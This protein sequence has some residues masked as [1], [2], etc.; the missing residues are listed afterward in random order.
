[1]ADPTDT[2][3]QCDRRLFARG[4]C[5][6]HYRQWQIETKAVPCRVPACDGLTGILGTGKGYCTAHY[7]KLRTYGDPLH[8]ERK[9]N[10]CIIDGCDEV[11]CGHGLCSKHYT[12]QKR[13]GSTDDPRPWAH[14]DEGEQWCGACRQVKPDAEMVAHAH[15]AGIKRGTCRECIRSRESKRRADDPERERARHRRWYRDNRTKALATAARRRAAVRRASIIEFSHDQL[16]A[17]LTMF[18]GCWMCGTPDWSDIDHVKPIAAGGAHCLSNLRPAC[19]PCNRSK[20]ARW[21]YPM[22]A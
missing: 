18:P 9:R 14:L 7:Q 4:M 6:T 8:V 19:G 11:V 15:L 10:H 17:R 2:C 16:S 20:G 12:R 1:M 21:P 22:S 3:T 13:Y 5:S